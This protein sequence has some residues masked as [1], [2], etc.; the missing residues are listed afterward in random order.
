MAW[1]W[2]CVM[3][4]VSALL[5]GI[6]PSFC[7]RIIYPRFSSFKAES[8]ILIATTYAGSDVLNEMYSKL[9]RLLVDN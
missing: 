3:F 7:S 2:L 4:Y 9:G 1:Q 5:L 6:I 8:C